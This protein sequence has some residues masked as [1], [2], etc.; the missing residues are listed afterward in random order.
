MWVYNKALI[1]LEFGP[2]CDHSNDRES[3]PYPYIL[4]Y[5]FPTMCLRSLQLIW[6]PGFKNTTKAKFIKYFNDKTVVFNNQI[7]TGL[8]LLRTN[9]CKHSVRLAAY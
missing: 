8:L 1:N 2:Y 5:T 7:I 9:G 6:R 3:K 4:K